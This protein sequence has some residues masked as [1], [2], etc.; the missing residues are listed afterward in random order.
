MFIW[1]LQFGEGE[2][3]WGLECQGPRSAVCGLT[4]EV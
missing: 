2:I 1:G 3:I 4:F